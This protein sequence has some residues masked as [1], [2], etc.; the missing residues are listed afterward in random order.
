MTRKKINDRQKYTKELQKI[1]GKWLVL[2][3]SATLRTV[4]LISFIHLQTWSFVTTVKPDLSDYDSDGVRLA[5][6]SPLTHKIVY[7]LP[8]RAGPLCSTSL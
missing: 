8:I 3:L 7:P 2:T 4:T 1:S 5:F 6:L